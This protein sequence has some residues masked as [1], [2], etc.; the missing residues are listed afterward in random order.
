M[1]RQTLLTAAV[2]AALLAPGDGWA[3]TPSPCTA[4]AT[5]KVVRRGGRAETVA[6][7]VLQCMNPSE[8]SFGT[9]AVLLLDPGQSVAITDGLADA[10]VILNDPAPAQ[11]T[12]GELGFPPANANV[13]VGGEV[14]SSGVVF[15]RIPIA[16]DAQ[17]RFTTRITNVRIDTAT[18]TSAALTLSFGPGQTTRTPIRFSNSNQ[19]GAPFVS[20]GPVT[21]AEVEPMPF[22][23]RATTPSAAVHVGGAGQTSTAPLTVTISESF[24]SA[25]RKRIETTGG[26]EPAGTPV[27]QN[28]PG[29]NYYTESGF[30]PP[31]ENLTAANAAGVADSGTRFAVELSQIS[32]DIAFRAPDCV[33]A[34]GTTGMALR[35]VSGFGSDFSGGSLVSSC[36]MTTVEPRQGPVSL[37][38]EVVGESG[39]HGGET[40]D[41]YAI[42]FGATCNLTAPLSEGPGRVDQG[43]MLVRVGA[44]PIRAPGSSLSEGKAQATPIPFPSFDGRR[45]DLGINL[46]AVCAAADAGPTFTSNGFTDA[47]AFGR[48]PSGGALASL[49]GDFGASL[50]VASS[51]PLPTE[52]GG[53]RVEFENVAAALGEK[54]QG[55]PLLAP[56]AFVSPG[57][58]NLQVPWEVNV[59][60]GRVRARVTVGDK[61]SNTVE[62]PI[63][64]VSPGI[65]SFNFGPGAA[66]AINPDGSVAHAAGSV[67]G[68][69]S[70]PVRIG[71]ALII[72]A[73]GLGVT[74]PPAVTGANS[75]DAQGGFVQRDAVERPRVTIG[76]VAQQVLFAGMSPE[77][78]GVNQINIVVQPGTPTGNAISL[79]IET[80]TLRSRDDVTVAVAAAGN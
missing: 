65:F 63:G 8:N 17:G 74:N 2:L 39:V 46:S 36:G 38:Y 23:F 40:L 34:Q 22:S 20:P 12:R 4:T 1:T 68:V 7:I 47:A 76:G 5:S 78:V 13:F 27:P 30:T 56:L 70:R 50:A 14:S 69:T 48:P 10:V 37:L 41:T 52:L 54:A 77:F 15:G 53:V 80:G 29:M 73:T 49:F 64:P 33:P 32:A 19:G 59:A 58:I 24:P 21:L 31:G 51:I 43:T 26:P 75:L 44:G 9:E 61:T 11:Q 28:V 62:L 60:S 57:Q 18:P 42:P 6:D 66:V 16:K 3:Q 55:A 25:A 79:I 45:A 67:P 72:L 71:E 35:R